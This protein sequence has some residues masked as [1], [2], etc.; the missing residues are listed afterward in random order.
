[1]LTLHL[2]KLTC[3]GNQCWC[4]N[5]LNLATG[6]E[7]VASEDCNVPCAGNSAESCGGTNLIEV[8]E[9]AS[10]AK[11]VVGSYTY[12][13]CYDNLPTRILNAYYNENTSGMTLETCASICAGY[14]YF[15][16]ENG[17]LCVPANGFTQPR[18]AN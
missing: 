15:G 9:V 7:L 18:L 12:S 8:Y 1:M 10:T 6:N 13:G 17:T 3:I 14:N 11:T 4:S 16:V 2:T 5:S